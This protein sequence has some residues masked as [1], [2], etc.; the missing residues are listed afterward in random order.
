MTL[1]S[2]TILAW[3]RWES[4]YSIIALGVLIFLNGFFNSFNQISYA[5][6]RDLMPEEMSGTAMTGIN[7][8]TMMGAGVFVHGLGEVIGHLQDKSSGSDDIY[9]LSFLICAGA[10][11][12]SAVLYAFTT[13]KRDP[14]R[15]PKT[16]A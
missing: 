2:F 1:S 7:V 6:I 16:A 3:S 14:A 12:L 9:R 4:S 5:H 11:F 8:F 15:Y 10:V 13:E